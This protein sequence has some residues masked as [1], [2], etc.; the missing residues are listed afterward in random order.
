MDLN[1]AFAVY[2]VTSIVHWVHSGTLVDFILQKWGVCVTS[3]ISPPQIDTE[4]NLVL[5]GVTKHVPFG[6]I[7]ALDISRRVLA[8]YFFC[9]ERI[10]G[11]SRRASLTIH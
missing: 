10:G 7:K 6:F 4:D 1:L 3:P 9:N 5:I 8:F 11:K 2:L